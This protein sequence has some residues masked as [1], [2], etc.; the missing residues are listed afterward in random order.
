MQPVAAVENNLSDVFY[1]QLRMFKNNNQHPT[2]SVK[3]Y[4]SFM[5]DKYNRPNSDRLGVTERE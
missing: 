4:D 5:T 3:F 2:I 1:L